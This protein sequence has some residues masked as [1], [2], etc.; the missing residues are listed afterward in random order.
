MIFYNSDNSIHN[1][2]PFCRP[3]FCHSSVV[4]YTA[5]SLAKSSFIC[6]NHWWEYWWHN[7]RMRKKFWRGRNDLTTGRPAITFKFSDECSFSH[8]TL[9][10]LNIL[11]VQKS[12]ERRKDKYIFIGLQKSDKFPQVKVCL[13]R[14]FLMHQWL[15][16]FTTDLNIFEYV[17]TSVNIPTLHSASVCFCGRYIVWFNFPHYLVQLTPRMG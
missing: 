2:R 15:D 9:Q 13:L 8:E 3:L 16:V 17:N 14:H 4:M 11:P 10:R 12:L 1:L 5:V 6:Y 7:L